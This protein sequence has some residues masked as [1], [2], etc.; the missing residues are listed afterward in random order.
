MFRNSKTLD[1]LRI[2]YAAT[3][4]ALAV[5]WHPAPAAQ[6]DDLR[7]EDLK[8]TEVSSVSRPTRA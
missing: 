6:D 8:K 7:L 4:I 1:A 2:S 5:A 3:A